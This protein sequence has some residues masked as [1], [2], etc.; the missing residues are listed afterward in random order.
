MPSDFVHLHVHTEYSLLDGAGRVKDLLQRAKAL[1]MNSLAITDHG[2]LYGI[3]NFYKT[4][5]KLG[6][7]PIIGCEVYV[8]PRDRQLREE[9]NGIRYYHLILLA[10]NDLG[11]RNLFKLISRANTEGFYYKPRV[12]K[13]LLRK[14]HVGLIAL[15]ACVAGEIP[16]AILNADL[17]RADELVREYVD[18][19]GRENFFLEIQNHGLPEE[20][21]V[22][23]ALLELAR[24]HDLKL[25]ATNDVHYVNREDAEFHDIML[26]IQTNSTFD[27][28]TRLRFNS[29]DYYLKSPDEMSNLFP[30]LPEAI[31][32][33]LEIA[34]RCNVSFD[35]NHM[36]LP[37]YALPAPYSNAAMYLR[38]LCFE[39]LPLRYPETTAKIR[40]RLEHELS[41][42]HSMGYDNYF[43]IVRDF[44]QY[45][46]SRGIAVGPGRGSAA[47]SVVAYILGITDLEPMKLGLLF[48]RFLNPERVSMPDIDVDFC[49]RR[50]EE[51][52]EYVKQKYGKTHVGQIITFGTMAAKAA[53]R[54][55]GRVLKLS[56]AETGRIVKM[57]PNELK[58]TLEQALETSNELR[59]AFATDPNV[60]RVIE[61]A[62]KLEGLP[63]HSSVHAAGLVIAPQP[64]DELV[65]VQQ[66]GD[67]LVTQFDKDTL[68]ELGLL[69]MDFLGLRTLTALQ[70]AIENIKLNYAAF[71]VKPI[72]RKRKRGAALQLSLFDSPLPNVESIPLEDGLTARML[73]EGK[74]GAVFQLESAGITKLVRE[75]RPQCFADLIP[76]VA[77]YR[78]GPLGSGMVQDFID[79]KNGKISVEYMHPRL[80]P[81]SKETYGVILYQEQVMEIVRELAGFTLGRADI[82]RR[83]MGKKKS[84]VLL[85]Q[86]KD[87]VDGCIARDVKRTLAEKIF[88][89]LLHF[90]DYGFNKSHSAAYGLLT[91]RMAY[92]KANYPAEYMA[93]MLSSVMDV[94][95]TTT[96]CELARRMGLTLLGPDINKSARNFCVSD[97]AVRF[98]LAAIWNISDGVVDNIIATREGGG[99]FKSLPDFC[100]RVDLRIVNRRAIEVLIKSGAFDSLDPR[101]TA[102]LALVENAVTAAENF[103][104]EQNSGHFELFD[105]EKYISDIPVPDVEEKPKSVLLAWEKET[106]GLYFSGHPL[107]EFRDKIGGLLTIKEISESNFIE[108]K[109]LKIAGL[110]TGL[111]R[112]TTQRGDTMCFITLEDATARMELTIFPSV[113]R[114]KKQL[115]EENN[116]IVIESIIE[117][118]NNEPTPAVKEI[119]GAAQYKPDYYLTVGDDSQVGRIDDICLKHRGTRSV[120]IRQL[121]SWQ[122]R[123]YKVD[124]SRE[125]QAEL[126]ELLGRENVRRS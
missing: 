33:T 22:T 6:I 59:Q 102:L 121:G 73:A 61:M 122:R 72:V 3:I 50:R 26:C 41:T 20:F 118:Y 77:L 49:F 111:R 74:T 64:L 94:D 44:I 13:K 2:N 113:Y 27:D 75:L 68:E 17:N 56:V 47:G 24:R 124:D 104:A 43:L 31:E 117:I 60:R 25:V 97:G 101:R 19:F 78:P 29:D 36:K 86:K 98:G 5:R 18:I 32:N 84:D 109:R 40:A 80:A 9:V 120:L 92:L 114:K 10:E 90:A 105:G 48:E 85:A 57:M 103:R 71:N 108:G 16:R 99:N 30:E 96:Y 42:I 125:L 83:A 70:E 37:H 110:I 28:E 53:V 51:V 54:D 1:G 21:Q 66:T 88:E 12:D 38:A 81:I 116:A 82:L 69:K 55:V 8:A 11:C 58:F 39:Q 4:A 106:L 34:A 23:T 87:F 126:E 52:I 79:R 45:A 119:I 46:K 15:S 123:P 93:A 100:R 67:T 95:K 7:K 35:F 63:R 107:D 112:S 65:P 62:M 14:Y 89:L 115:L 91:W 76:I